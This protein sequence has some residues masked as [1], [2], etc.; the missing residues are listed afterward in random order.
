MDSDGIAADI[1]AAIERANAPE[2]TTAIRAQ[3]EELKQKLGITDY[4]ELKNK[5]V[6]RHRQITTATTVNAQL[7][8]C[9]TQEEF[10][11]AEALVRRSERDLSADDLERFQ[12]A[13]G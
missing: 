2:Q 11:A 9:K 1:R 4:T 12:I 13:L 5:V 3:V 7:K 10:S 8:A 6:K